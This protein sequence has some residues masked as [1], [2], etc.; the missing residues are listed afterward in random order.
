MAKVLACPACDHK[1]PLDLLVGL[2]SFVCKNC[3][4]KLAIPNEASALSSKRI[5]EPEKPAPKVQIE[6]KPKPSEEPVKVVPT[7]SEDQIVVLARAS[8]AVEEE[9]KNDIKPVPKSNE[10]KAFT[11][12]AKT[13][14]EPKI[15]KAPSG[16]LGSLISLSA[17]PMPLFGKI[18]AWLFAIPFGFFIVVLLPRFFKKGFHAS[19]FVDVIT[20]QGIG[21]YSIVVTLIFFWSMATVIGVFIFNLAFRKLFLL[22]KIAK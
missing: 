22:K 7:Q 9:P 20:R 10:P 21:R 6:Q 12:K 13:E 18:A 1:H 17:I 3:G 15:Q 5:Q 4:R 8:L 11:R 2:D 14:N 19:D 16:L